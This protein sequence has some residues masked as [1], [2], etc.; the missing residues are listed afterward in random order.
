MASLYKLTDIAITTD[1]DLDLNASVPKDIKTKAGTEAIEQAIYVRLKTELLGCKL[2]TDM[3]QDLKSMLGK[4]I[5]KKNCEKVKQILSKALTFGNV[6]DIIN[7]E[8]IPIEGDCIYVHCQIL[9]NNNIGYNF[10]FEYNFED[11]LLSEFK[12]DIL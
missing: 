7:I 4:R 6:F 1:G 11:S 9:L 10:N 5:I 3:G 2:W 8:V 12:F